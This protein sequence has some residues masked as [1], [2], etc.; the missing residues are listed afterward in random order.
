MMGLTKNLEYTVSFGISASFCS[1]MA[2]LLFFGID[3]VNY[4]K[5]DQA[6]LPLKYST[7]NILASE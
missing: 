7:S 6:S 5:K 1:F 2:L 4:E 3:D